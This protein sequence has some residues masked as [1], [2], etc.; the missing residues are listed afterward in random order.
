MSIYVNAGSFGL[1]CEVFHFQGCRT[2]G[3][4]VQL[5]VF[6]AMSVEPVDGF[7]A[8]AA[9]GLNVDSNGFRFHRRFGLSCRYGRGGPMAAIEIG[10]PG[11]RYPLSGLSPRW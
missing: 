8:P 6:K 1:A 11:R 7:V 2:I 9:K 5:G 4:D 3:C 10:I